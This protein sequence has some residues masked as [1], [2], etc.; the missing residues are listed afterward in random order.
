MRKLTTLLTLLLLCVV[1]AQA[2]ATYT[3]SVGAANGEFWR[4]DGTQD[5]GRWAARF[6][7]NG[8]PQVTVSTTENK[9]TVALQALE[10]IPVPTP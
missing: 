6:V 4:V 2:A 3:V 5:A 9:F 7:S 10:L 8:E 1:G